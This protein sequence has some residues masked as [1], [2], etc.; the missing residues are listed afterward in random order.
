MLGSACLHFCKIL[1]ES[2]KSCNPLYFN[3]LR[4]VEFIFVYSKIIAIFVVEILTTL[5]DSIMGAKQIIMFRA[6]GMKSVSGMSFSDCM[7]YSWKMNTLYEKMNNGVV[8]LEYVKLD[9]T[10]VSRKGTLVKDYKGSGKVAF[11][12]F[13]N[14]FLAMYYDIEKDG[15]RILDIR[16]TRILK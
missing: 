13:S 4:K 16:W 7:K 2:N 10:M 9:G 3:S 11:R 6:W 12:V 1:F 14:P 8:E 15:I 5:N